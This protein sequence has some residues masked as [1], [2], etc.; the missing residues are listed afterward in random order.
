MWK[1]IIIIFESKSRIEILKDKYII[2]YD[3]LNLKLN[4]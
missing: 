3:N 4:F 2:Y 1:L